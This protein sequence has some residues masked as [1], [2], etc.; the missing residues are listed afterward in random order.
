MSDA[1]ALNH[2][3]LSAPSAGAVRAL[4][5][6]RASSFN[7]VNCTTAA[8]RLATLGARDGGDARD[9]LPAALCARA[10]AL[11]A[12]AA[13]GGAPARNVANLLWALAKTGTRA[14]P[15]I[16]ALVRAARGRLAAEFKPQELSSTAWAL[17]RMG[18]GAA[19][20]AFLLEL[21]GALGAALAASTPQAIA[22]GAWAF[23]TLATAGAL[24]GG[25]GGAAGALERAGYAPGAVAAAA[26]RRAAEFSPQELANVA[27]AL[28]KLVGADAAAGA[29]RAPCARDCGALA[30][31]VLAALE[32][33]GAQFADQQLA[34]ALW[35]CARLA[36]A[37]RGARADADADAAGAAPLGER[38]GRAAAACAPRLCRFR[39]VEL[40]MAAWAAVAAQAGVAYAPDGAAAPGGAPASPFARALRA[41]VRGRARERSLSGS[42]GAQLLWAF[43]HLEG[44][45]AVAP[46][47]ALCAALRRDATAL[48]PLDLSNAWWALARIGR[49]PPPRAGRALRKATRRALRATQGGKSG[50]SALSPQH[51]A[52]V[53]WAAARLGPP[54]ADAR[55][56]ALLAAGAARAARAFN[57]RDLANAM[58]GFA[59]LWAAGVGATRPT[60]AAALADAA[61]RRLDSFNAQELL[62]FAG[63]HA[64]AGGRDERLRE[65]MGAARELRFAFPA[66][67]APDE[68]A[69]ADAGIDAAGL[70][71]TL[72]SRAPGRHLKHTGVAAWEAS[73]T[74][75]QWLSS[76]P[77]PLS[78]GALRGALLGG[79]DRTG[80]GDARALW[81]QWAGTTAVELGAGLGLPSIVAAHRGCA[82]VIATDGDG[83]T[84]ELLRHNCAR[85]APPLPA[86]LRAA[87]LRWGIADALGACGLEQPPDVLLAADVVYGHAEPTWRAL[88]DSMLQL[89]GARTLVLQ[90]Q[91]QRFGREATDGCEPRFR[92]MLAEH[93]M[94]AQVP[95]DELGACMVADLARTNCT[96]HVLRR[97][98][99][100]A[101]VPRA[102]AFTRPCGDERA[103]GEAS[104][105]VKRP[106]LARVL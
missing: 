75:S 87:E 76:Q 77:A 2:E 47:R 94:A 25:G 98:A 62:K 73:V 23:A 37:A 53:V 58:S 69:D 61:L 97:R 43:A 38:L 74:L 100:G 28:G 91:V 52:T 11:V 51:V 104:A 13:A 59:A 4:V 30:D 41:A 8:H 64:R 88:L 27:W 70:C 71:V 34:N 57:A 78:S 54:T 22:N 35:G 39:G 40:A 79:G 16:A 36:H 99:A 12:R 56:C 26:A 93:F 50:G 19:D 84:L 72:A 48:A 68:A 45:A 66:L 33:R 80:G 29:A 42:Q 6:V 89:A 20:E 3:L 15:L 46:V 90:A 103:D 106:R 101:R 83:P 85:N 55:L 82:L 60:L 18:E 95:P 21:A 49:P 96:V 67:R 10:A 81:R 63:A 9:G 86:V 105:R 7:I 92:A 1:R 24:G 102:L 5:A 65:A 31:A 14:P 17:A 44:G 32:A